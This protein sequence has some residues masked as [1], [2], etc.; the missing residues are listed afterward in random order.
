MSGQVNQLR[1]AV[2]KRKEFLINELLE[3]DYYNSADVRQL[4]EHTLT[5]LE[6]IHIGVKC[7]HG[8]EMTQEIDA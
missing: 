3:Y 7:Q 1:E 2:D 5:E 6:M 8:R 4:Y